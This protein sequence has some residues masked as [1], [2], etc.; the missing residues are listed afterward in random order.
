[1]VAKK[2]ALLQKMVN[3]TG[4]VLNPIISVQKIE[5]FNTIEIDNT[6]KDKRHHAGCLKQQPYTKYKQR[7]VTMEI[8]LTVMTQ[9][10]E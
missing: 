8:L 2:S 5:P 10:L 1:M 6:G 9:I 7:L 3:N 4:T